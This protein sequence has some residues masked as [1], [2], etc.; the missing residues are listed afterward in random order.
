[1]TEYE[2][3]DAY[4]SVEAS[5]QGAVS[6]YISILFAYLATAYFVG[7][8]LTRSQ[9][10]IVTGLYSLF[11][12]FMLRMLATVLIRMT[13]LGTEILELSPERAVAGSRMIGT[14]L[15]IWGSVFIGSYV[16]GLVF[17][18]QLRRNAK[19]GATHRLE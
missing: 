17:M 15:V 13:Q 19:K 7:E 11:S 10:V 12:L 1:M 6:I 3:I 14:G 9:V 2:L 5:W 16:A 4:Q 8:K 18:F